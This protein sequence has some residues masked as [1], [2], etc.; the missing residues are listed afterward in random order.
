MSNQPKP[1]SS[2]A[3]V[4]E[5]HGRKGHVPLSTSV[6]PSLKDHLVE[7]CDHAGVTM[8]HAIEEALEQFLYE[9]RP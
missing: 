1:G 7:Y 5:R 3:R 9:V 6:P 4:A 8:K 2:S